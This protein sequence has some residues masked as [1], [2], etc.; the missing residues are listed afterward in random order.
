MITT[1]CLNPS[2]DKTVEVDAMTVGGLHRVR[3]LRTDPGG[4]GSNVAAVLVR[5]GA[6]TRCLGLAGENGAAQYEAMLDQ[7]GVPHG[8]LHMPGQVRTNLKIVSL[9]GAEVTEIN[10]PGPEVN[11]KLLDSLI[12]LARDN[13]RGDDFIILTGSLPPGCSHDTYARVMRA[14]PVPCVLDASGET[15]RQ[16]LKATPFLVKPNLQELSD[17]A[18]RPLKTREEIREAAHRMIAAGARNV[19][20]SMGAGGALLVNPAGALFSPG[21]RVPVSSTVGAGDAMTAGFV[22]GFVETG[23]F[24]EAM[25]RGMAAGAASVMTDG[26]QLIRREDYDALLGKVEIQEV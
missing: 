2:F 7:I 12:R 5:L 20:V 17:Q 21:L 4:K 18:G 8:F 14:L 9:D 19:L 22:A 23:S 10:E 3:R 6:Q 1:L 16:S 24:R 25:R 26:T 15:L 11:I 13:C